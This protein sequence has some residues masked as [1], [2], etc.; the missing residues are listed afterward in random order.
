MVPLA[1]AVFGAFRGTG[2]LRNRL[3]H[4]AEIVEKLPESA[5]RTELLELVNDEVKALRQYD[6]GT[7]N[8][9]MLVVA[10]IGAAICWYGAI[11]LVMRATW[12]S[13]PAGVV[14][15]FV[16]LAFTYGIFESAQRVQRDR[17]GKQLPLGEIAR[18]SDEQAG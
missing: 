7:R 3:R 1:T 10:I 12:W 9:T 6:A 13:V 8:W 16:A 5:A 17:D 18:S 15:G 2:A 4:D 14:V 11:W